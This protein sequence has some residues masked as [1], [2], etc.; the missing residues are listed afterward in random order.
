MD[1]LIEKLPDDIVIQIYTKYL[2]KYRFHDGKFIKL[3]DFKKYKFLE[4]FI[5]RKMVNVSKVKSYDENSGREFPNIF[6]EIK[7]Q[8]I[9]SIKKNIHNIFI[10]F[11]ILYN[12]QIY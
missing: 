2:R 5:S 7:K 8:H 10:L 3:I 6:L 1:S 12:I 11:I 9:A 4:K